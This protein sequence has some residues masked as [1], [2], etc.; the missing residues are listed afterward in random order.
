MSIARSELGSFAPEP[1]DGL[2]RTR[3]TALV[4]EE[5]FEHLL[6]RERKRSERSNRPFI[7]LLL[8]A[9]GSLDPVSSRTG[10]AIIEALLAGT[11][12]TDILGWAE[13]PTMIG[14][15]FPEI[16]AAQPAQAVTSS[17]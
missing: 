1:R 11:R 13:S 12:A 2:A 9:G 3:S 17:A 6:V 10:K 7:L 14:V 4:S 8:S 5:V 15:I 16:G